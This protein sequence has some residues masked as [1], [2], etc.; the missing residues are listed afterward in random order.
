MV[1]KFDITPIETPVLTLDQAKAQLRVE[2]DWTEEDD[3]INDII[4][5]AQDVAE[6]YMGRPCGHSMVLECDNF[7]AVSAIQCLAKP[8]VTHVKYLPEGETEYVV[9]GAEN[10]TF[11]KL[12]RGDLYSLT[13][14]QTLPD[15]AVSDAAV[16]VTLTTVCPPAVLRGILLILTDLY[17]RREDRVVNM[18]DTLAV[19]YLRIY[20]QTW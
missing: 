3:F 1:K 12:Y 2:L 14:G 19:S 4:V 16:V 15:L 18:A 8:E 5:Q 20:K 6:Q 11:E 7:D 17:E 9:L 10:Y 13:F